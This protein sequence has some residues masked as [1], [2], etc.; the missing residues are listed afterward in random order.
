[1]G[2][3]RLHMDESRTA[4]GRV[5]YGFGRVYSLDVL[6]AASRTASRV[7]TRST[8]LRARRRNP[9]RVDPSIV[10]RVNVPFGKV[11]LQVVVP[12]LFP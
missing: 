11:G 4:P 5:A 3:V 1:M 2:R 7:C 8:W 9:Q 10:A 6:P 12:K